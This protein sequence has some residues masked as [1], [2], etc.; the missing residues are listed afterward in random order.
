VEGRPF[1]TQA[2][3]GRTPAEPALVAA[4]AVAAL[5][6][7][8]ATAGRLSLALAHLDLQPHAFSWDTAGGPAAADART[9]VMYDVVDALEAEVAVGV[10]AH[11]RAP[12]PPLQCSAARCA[13]WGEGAARLCCAF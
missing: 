2:P 1:P 4:T 7:R 13:Q 9:A 10:L 11:Q 6:E 3:D 8:A 5:V 12:S